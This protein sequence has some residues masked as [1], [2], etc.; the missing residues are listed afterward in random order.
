MVT[1][2]EDI[3][4]LGRIV[5]VL[6]VLDALLSKRWTLTQTMECIQPRTGTQFDSLMVTALS[7]LIAEAKLPYSV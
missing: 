4:L 1:S 5:A 6:D 3:P 7:R 2:S